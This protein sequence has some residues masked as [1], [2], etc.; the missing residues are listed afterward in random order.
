MDPREEIIG[1][2]MGKKQLQTLC[3]SLFWVTFS[4][5]FAEIS[6]LEW[7]NLKR[8]ALNR[9]RKVIYNTD[10]CDA[11]Y[12]PKNLKASKENF[13]KQRLVYALG[14]KIDTISYCPVS[15]GFGYLT[16]KTVVGDQLL[17]DS[18][19]AKNTYNVTGD[20]LKHGTDP[21]KIAEEFCRENN[22]EF[23]VSLRCNDTH[24]KSHKFLFPP[25]KINN[26]GLLMGNRCL[27]PP[28]ASW[29]AV[30]FT[31]EKVRERFLNIVKELMTNYQADGIEL[32]FCRH[33]QYFKSVAWG[34]HASA[35]ECE[36][37]TDCMR[38][39]RMMAERIGRRRGRPILISV[40]LPD[41]AEYAKAVGLDIEKW[42]QEKLIDI[43]IG[44][45]YFRLNP[46]EKSVKLCRKY[47]I[48]FYPSMNESR[49]SKVSWSF[50]RNQLIT[51]RARQAAALQA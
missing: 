37:M 15:S 39:I 32:D 50:Y 18:P 44:G 20:L 16:S 33:L 14:S 22:F 23:F 5:V 30:D 13:I 29:S 35:R 31:H 28:H 36:K 17:N 4:T 42:M 24:D 25:F 46:W 38:K 11:L 47:G 6:D 8:Q 7:A 45:F 19:T 48:K 43:Y 51:Y 21:L 27:R 49:I 2:N 40:R 12:F 9:Q 1:E 41:S 34:K 10:G 26:P 3:L